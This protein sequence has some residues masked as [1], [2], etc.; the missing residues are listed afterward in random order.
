MCV[1]CICVHVRSA[2][3]QLQP[4]LRSSMSQWLKDRDTLRGTVAPSLMID[5]VVKCIALVILF[6]KAHQNSVV[7]YPSPNHVLSLIIHTF[8]FT[9]HRDGLLRQHEFAHYTLIFSTS[10]SAEYGSHSTSSSPAHC[11]PLLVRGNS[12]S[13]LLW[14]SNYGVVTE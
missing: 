11:F 10:R 3:D 2:L 13:D 12:R 9:Y 4:P 5:S 6:F 7:W 14:P 8:D 1:Q